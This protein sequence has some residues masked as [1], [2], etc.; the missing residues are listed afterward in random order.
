MEMT[1]GD[2]TVVDLVVDAEAATGNTFDLVELGMNNGRTVAVAVFSG[3][4]T[5]AIA[6]AMRNLNQEDV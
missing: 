4:H 1:W 6:E 5:E 2:T 3:P